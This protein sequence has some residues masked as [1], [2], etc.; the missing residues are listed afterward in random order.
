MN[1]DRRERYPNIDDSEHNSGSETDMCDDFSMFILLDQKR[2]KIANPW[3]SSVG[4]PSDAQDTV[5]KGTD[6][7]IPDSQSDGSAAALSTSLTTTSETRYRDSIPQVVRRDYWRNNREK[8]QTPSQSGL[9]LLASAAS[10][11]ESSQY[12]DSS[13]F[14]DC[15][16]HTFTTLLSSLSRSL[17]DI[18]D[19]VVRLEL[20]FDA[21]SENIKAYRCVGRT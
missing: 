1:I 20:A 11:S 15:P 19:E 21:L 13:R 7:V 12:S 3:K 17:N 14:C 16:L 10:Q 4:N 2:A 18:K 8:D 9:Y 5:I 6:R